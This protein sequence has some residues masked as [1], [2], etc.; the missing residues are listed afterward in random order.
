MKCS[1]GDHIDSIDKPGFCVWCDQPRAEWRAKPCPAQLSSGLA[2]AVARKQ[3][4]AAAASVAVAAIHR[5]ADSERTSRDVFTNLARQYAPELGVLLK[6][7]TYDAILTL[8]PGTK[9]GHIAGTLESNI[10]DSRG[11]RYALVQGLTIATV[12]V[13]LSRKWS[14]L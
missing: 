1:N 13:E 8:G 7:V 11:P 14:K 12:L 2:P 6:A 3:Q 4:E 9:Q 10:G 5:A